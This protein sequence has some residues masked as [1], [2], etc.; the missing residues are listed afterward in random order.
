MSIEDY[1]PP[2]AKKTKGERTRDNILGC[3]SR[4]FWKNSFHSVNT[5]EI[6]KAAGVN[7]ATLYR[8]FSSKEKLAVGVVQYNM[9]RTRN[10]VFEESFAEHDAPAKRLDSIYRRVYATHRGVQDAGE[11]CPGCPFVNIGMELATQSPAVRHAVAASQEAFVGYY[12]KIVR[13]V[14][15]KRPASKRMREADTAQALA[16]LMN[17]ALVAAKLKDDPKEILT[18]LPAAK[19]LAGL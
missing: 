8:H 10:Y 16:N 19:Q 17:G 18:T 6:C 13:A 5:D 14:N 12:K 15:A 3:A 4:L 2:E 11:P 7:K 9:E 1:A